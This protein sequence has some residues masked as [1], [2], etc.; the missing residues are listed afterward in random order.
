[1]VMFWIMET[2]LCLLL[3]FLQSEKDLRVQLHAYKHK[4]A[5]LTWSTGSPLEGD[6][7]CADSLDFYIDNDMIRIASVTV[8]KCY[9]DDFLAKSLKMISTFQGK[10]GKK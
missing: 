8:A 9:G 5:Q 1:M 2:F 10:T 7:A 3:L 4:M 6:R